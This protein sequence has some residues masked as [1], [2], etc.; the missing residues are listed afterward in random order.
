M[1]Y[2]LLILLE[3]LTLLLWIHIW[4]KGN[5]KETNGLGKF[6]VIYV[7]YYY[8]VSA[9]KLGFVMDILSW[10][11]IFIW[12]IY[13][14]KLRIIESLL[15]YIMSVMCVSVSQLIAWE[16]VTGICDVNKLSEA[17]VYIIISVVSLLG[18]LMIY[19]WFT[20]RKDEPLLFTA[21]SAFLI[22]YIGG[23]MLFIKYD[24]ESNNQG[25][26]HLY[27]ILFLLLIFFYTFILK[28]MKT[29]Y[30][31]EQKKSELRVR[32]KYENAYEQLLLEFR[33]KQHDYRNQITAIYSIGFLNKEKDAT[34]MLQQEYGAELLEDKEFDSLL[35]SCDNSVLAGY[36]Y[37]TCNQAK[38]LGVNVEVKL[39]GIQKEY[40]IPT[41]EIVEILG[42]LINNALEHIKE[43][44]GERKALRL[45]LYHKSGKLNIE[46][47]NNS[48][49]ISYEEL[50][51]MF[52][53][54]YS[55]KGNGHGIGLYSL[56]TVVNKYHGELLAE[57]VE[58]NNKNWIRFLV[59]I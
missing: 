29:T 14:F 54:N 13:E 16:M 38:R 56:K 19:G 42:I 35:T 32:E 21:Y 47:W 50:Q 30:A 52:E 18:A 6:V 28:N 26:S 12:I 31:L 10:L 1:I 58:D 11:A 55:T 23:I 27:I 59:K 36:V 44:E 37:T 51:K 8:I 34:L 5:L 41:H 17:T 40:N 48:E 46:V 33:R 7:T 43:Y 39:S 9:L 57:N 4:F 20:N 15:R 24:Y 45:Y 53:I 49:Y 2:A 3:C 22:L 25:Y